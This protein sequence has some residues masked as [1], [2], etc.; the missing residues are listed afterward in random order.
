[1]LPVHP[2]DCRWSLGTPISGTALAAASII[3]M[4]P[5]PLGSFTCGACFGIADKTVF[6]IAVSYPRKVRL[7]SMS[8]AKPID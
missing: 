4:R 7:T 1:M 3:P 6:K 5:E 8:L 2:Q